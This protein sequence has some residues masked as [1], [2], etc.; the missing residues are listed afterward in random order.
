MRKFKATA[1]AISLAC[2]GLGST[3]VT[4]GHDDDD[5]DDDM[6]V[7]INDYMP[8]RA[9]GSTSGSGDTVEANCP[10]DP[11]GNDWQGATATLKIEQEGESSW[12]RIKV[13]DAVPHTVFT[14]WMRIKGGAGYNDAG[15]P[16]TG[17][18]ATPLCSGT[19]FADLNAIS[20]WNDPAGAPSSC[21]SFTTD[22][23]G[24]ATFSADL[25]FPVVGGAYPFQQSDGAPARPG[26]ADL[27]PDVPTA[28]VDPRTGNGGPFLL[29]V[30][31]HCTDQA[32]HGLSPA[33]REA[34]F[35]YP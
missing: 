10:T 7:V 30:I 29:R 33:V 1:I 6:S 17:G 24:N 15:S 35:Q 25:N 13:R 22:K 5:D 23:N 19:E 2:L 16:W 11:S 14:V 4:A 32:S 12:A 18:G 21:N 8:R 31:S 20:P 34:W 26:D 3:A 9:P 28:I 27:I